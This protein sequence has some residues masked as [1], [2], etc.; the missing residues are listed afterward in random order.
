ML[1]LDGRRNLDLFTVNFRQLASAMRNLIGVFGLAMILA[2]C[3]GTGIPADGN[4]Q[5]GAE[6]AE[7]GISEVP[8]PR[9]E[10]AARSGTPLATLQ[11]GHVTYML[12]CGECHNYM[13]PAQVDV[14]EWE[15]A[16]PKMIRHAGLAS[17][18]EKAVLSYVLA[19]KGE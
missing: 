12:K 17:E 6:P 2:S 13:L 15:D 5:T 10:M 8:N 7:G 18:D 1:A 16:M 11:H 19:V 14:D 9:A 3:G 4:I